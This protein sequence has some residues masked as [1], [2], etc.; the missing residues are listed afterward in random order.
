MTYRK[1]ASGAV[2]LVRFCC[3]CARAESIPI[4]AYQL[5]L[6]DIIQTVDALPLDPDQ[7]SQ[8]VTEIPDSV[9]VRTGTG[10]IQVNHPALKDD[11]AAF[12]RSDKDK[13][14]GHL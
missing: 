2:L 8:L 1:R 10:E 6:N 9:A 12:P 7:A 13:R 5:Q 14:S 11:L 4:A 3:A